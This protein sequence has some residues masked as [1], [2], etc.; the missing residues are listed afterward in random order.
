[1]PGT[2][3]Q[4][5]K[6][7]AHPGASPHSSPLGHPTA[8]T[9]SSAAAAASSTAAATTAVTAT[10]TAPAASKATTC[11]ND[12]GAGE[13]ATRRAIG[14]HAC[15]YQRGPKICADAAVEKHTINVGA[16]ATAER[17]PSPWSP[18]PTRPVKPNSQQV[19]HMVP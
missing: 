1:M 10:S 11:G 4:G 19:S 16:A 14:G 15:S 9:A 18:G 13:H 3:Q 7:G 5:Q 12:N 6:A 2:G 8:A 17:P